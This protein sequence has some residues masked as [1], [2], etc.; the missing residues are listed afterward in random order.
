MVQIRVK[1]NILDFGGHLERRESNRFP[2]QEAMQFRVINGRTENFSGVGRTLD[3]SSS[4]IYF[5]TD[6]PPQLGRMVE[7][8]V[9]WPAR[10]G[11]TC[12]LKFVA[13][14]RVVRADERRVALRIERYEFRTRATPKA[15]IAGAT[16]A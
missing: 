13:V 12:A 3:M 9:D 7:V 16:F 6:T 5:A 1:E 2:L 10:L 4:G 11:G 14:G 8:S 15:A